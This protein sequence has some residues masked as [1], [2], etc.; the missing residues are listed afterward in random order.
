MMELV[1]WFRRGLAVAFVACSMS[2]AYAQTDDFDLYLSYADSVEVSLDLANLRSLAFSNTDR[3]MIVAYR[4]GSSYTHDY[5]RIG[6][7]YFDAL[8]NGMAE[9]LPEEKNILY[10]LV[11]RVLTLHGEGHN[12]ALY[13][14]N[15]ALIMQLE[16]CVVRLDRLPAGIYVL[17]VNNQTAK[18]CVR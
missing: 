17:R 11:G 14:M 9:S 5:S 4:N 15:G 16:S 3:T 1:S 6:K 18:L 13:N 10:T 8:T 2:L 12:S 7:L